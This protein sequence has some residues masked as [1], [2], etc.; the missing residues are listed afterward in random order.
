[1]NKINLHE[2]VFDEIL[3]AIKTEDPQQ[4]ITIKDYLLTL[5]DRVQKVP[6]GNNIKNM[7]I[8]GSQMDHPI[9]SIADTVT[10]SLDSTISKGLKGLNIDPSS[11]NAPKS[12]YEAVE[13]IEG[14]PN[15]DYSE[16]DPNKIRRISENHK[17]VATGIPEKINLSL[18]DNAEGIEPS[19][20]L[21]TLYALNKSQEKDKALC[22]FGHH[23]M[24]G[25]SI[26][27]HCENGLSI[28]LSGRPPVNNDFT[29]W[30]I[31][32]TWNEVVVQ[33]QG[34]LV[35][36]ILLIDG[37]IPNS[38]REALQLQPS[39]NVKPLAYVED[40]K[41]GTFRKFYNISSLNRS[42]KNSPIQLNFSN[43]LHREFVL[44][45]LPM[46][47][48]E[49]RPHIHGSGN[50]YRRNLL[51]LKHKIE[52][53]KPDHNKI[54]KH[55]HS[56]LSYEGAQLPVDIILFKKGHNEKEKKRLK[57]MKLSLVGN[58]NVLYSLK[59]VSQAQD[60]HFFRRKDFDKYSYIKDD[61]FIIVNC[62]KIKLPF[63][64]IFKPSRD[65]LKEGIRTQNL[66][67]ELVD[68]ISNHAGI[69]QWNKERADSALTSSPE[70]NNEINNTLEQLVRQDPIMKKLF[71]DGNQIR[72]I[73]TLGTIT[74]LPN[75]ALKRYPTFFT[76]EKVYSSSKPKICALN[77]RFRL[78]YLSDVVDNYLERQ[79]GGE[80]KVSINGDLV[81]PQINRNNGH[82]Y[83]NCNLPLGTCVG[84]EIYVKV[85]LKD[86]VKTFD[87]EAYIKVSEPVS[88]S[89]SSIT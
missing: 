27:C 70:S 12:P 72:D 1:M 41:F 77:R 11:V 83:I 74:A 65:G 36:Y 60:K 17:I 78:V 82:F 21:D 2:I 56:F 88:N 6:Y 5:D 61:L 50:D 47:L 14:V 35:Q 63:P 76:P 57:N 46:R 49:C 44:P 38:K 48:Y 34:R 87:E 42:I 71:I 8:I 23:S 18:I 15:G 10:N 68:L 20:Q 80:L 40:F 64:G 51:G 52:K 89:T 25:S 58:V 81:A 67:K 7:S 9:A 53:L 16:V 4:V 69:K 66:K 75:V 31:T 84:D 19:R 62:D 26:L 22:F 86:Q 28:S 29:H 33:G 43:E 85:K 13:L 59:G 45:P 79:D 32:I 24:G 73:G 39:D 54:E 37:Q 3:K 55:T 30:G